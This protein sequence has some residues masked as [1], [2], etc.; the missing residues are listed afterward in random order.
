M[1]YHENDEDN[2][3][4]YYPILYFF[5]HFDEGYFAASAAIIVFTALIWLPLACNDKTPKTALQQK[6]KAYRDCI[7]NNVRSEEFCRDL[8]K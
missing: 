8:T 7:E 4:W 2:R 5:D 6:V 3:R 1:A